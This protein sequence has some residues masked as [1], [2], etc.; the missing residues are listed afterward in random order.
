MDVVKNLV[1]VFNG[2]LEIRSKPG[3]GST[4]IIQLPLSLAIIQALLV[5]VNGCTYAVSL[6]NVSEIIGMERNQI[7]TIDSR[8]VLLLRDEVI[9]MVFLN[10]VFETEGKNS[11]A[12]GYLYAVI[13]DI[14]N[15]K[16]GLAVDNL[17]GKQ[18][19]VIKTLAG[20]LRDTKYFSGA[21]ILGDGRVILILD[22][23]AVAG[24]QL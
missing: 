22:A 7:R 3:V 23:A 9:P 13:V 18:E 20:M 19:I 17:I 2:K 10:K 21:T 15:E 14:N 6:T 4:F 8:E 1:E 24:V 5:E 12:A 11:G 16:V